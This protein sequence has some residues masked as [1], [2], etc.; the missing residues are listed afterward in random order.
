MAKARD[1]LAEALRRRGPEP[2]S[3]AEYWAR[4]KGAWLEELETLREQVRGWLRP[5]EDEKLAAVQ[6]RNFSTDEPDF[7]EYDAPGLEIQ[8]LGTAPKTVLLRPR[9]GRIQGV[10]E[11]PG[12]RVLGARG[13]VDLEH[14]LNREILLRLE[15]AGATRWYS[16]AGGKKRQLDEE[17]F[18]ELLAR[19]ADVT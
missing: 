18:F 19:V 12:R 13:R 2:E 5:L 8:L 6:D 16:F 3:V 7:G 1:K 11:A 9:G 14:G 10:I 17:L 4:Q 15:Q